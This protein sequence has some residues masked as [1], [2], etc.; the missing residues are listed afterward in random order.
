MQ[1]LRALFERF[2]RLCPQPFALETGS[3][4]RRARAPE[5]DAL[6]EALVNL[7]THQD[8]ADPS[9]TATILWWSDRVCFENPGDSYVPT[10]VLWS[11]GYS[12][13]GTPS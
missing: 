3:P 2:H 1:A 7:V 4:H 5:E 11:G 12:E 10:A 9:R 13:T 6:R 8:Y